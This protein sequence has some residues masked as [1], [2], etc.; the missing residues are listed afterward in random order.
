MSLAAS[1]TAL[2]VEVEV[3][4]KAGKAICKMRVRTN[5]QNCPNFQKELFRIRSL[6]FISYL[7]VTAVFH[8]F[9]E[10]VTSDNTSRN[11]IH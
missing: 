4:L 2:M 7:I 5:F 11:N 10:V 6:Y 1:K 3:Q 8:K 9:H